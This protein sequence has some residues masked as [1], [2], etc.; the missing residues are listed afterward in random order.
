MGSTLPNARNYT[1]DD[2]N[3]AGSDGREAVFTYTPSEEVHLN[4]SVTTVFDATIYIREAMCATGG[5]N[6]I[7]ADKVA[8]AGS[9]F[10][11]HE[12]AQAGTTYYFFVDGNGLN[13]NGDYTAT[14][15]ETIIAGDG[16]A[17]DNVTAV[18]DDGL[19]CD[20]AL[21]DPICKPFDCNGLAEGN[22][23]LGVTSMGDTSGDADENTMTCGTRGASTDEYWVLTADADGGLYNIDVDASFTVLPYVIFDRGSGMDCL[24]TEDVE[25]CEGGSETAKNFDIVLGANESAYVFVDGMFS[26]T[27]GSYTITADEVAFLASGASCNPAT[28][29]TLRCPSD[30]YCNVDTCELACGNGRLDPG[31]E[32]DDG[33]TAGGDACSATCQVEATYVMDSET[34]N[35][36]SVAT[37][38]MLVGGSAFLVAGSM[39][40]DAD[41]DFYGI[42][43]G[44]GDVLIAETRA[45]VASTDCTDFQ[46][47][48]RLRVFNSG[49]TQ[50]HP[51]PGGFVEQTDDIGF[52][53]SLCSHAAYRVPSAGTYYVAVDPA[54]FAT[55]RIFDYEL[56]AMLYTPLFV[57]VSES[58]P[59][60]SIAQA[61]TVAAGTLIT[62]EITT[63]GDTDFFQTLVPAGF[64]IVA[65][66]LDGATDTCS[67][68]DLDNSLD[69][70]DPDDALIAF[71]F[72]NGVGECAVLKE[73]NENGA[74]VFK[75]EN[76]NRPG[77]AATFDYT[78]EVLVHPN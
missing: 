15:S 49:G 28:Q 66:T 67:S 46:L 74:G 65:T 56:R 25:H 13:D 4:F 63:A 42:V 64:S 35:N 19:Y 41:V 57:G 43:A 32:C 55:D 11:T 77:L 21:P 71:D 29:G 27:K 10:V 60:N 47:D 20:V 23:A 5:G 75:V 9:E 48:S 62:G 22:L 70:F 26:F 52:F 16:D 30:E 72:F 44:A 53:T 78:L 12:R 39:L 6:D 50:V 73:R 58:E 14:V 51:P 18:C 37:A 76:N 17:C 1:T 59:N 33:G 45:P 31:E 68:G 2:S 8:G 34:E 7:C 40:D 36:N 69:L 38:Q 54:Q 3:C 24:V 61:E